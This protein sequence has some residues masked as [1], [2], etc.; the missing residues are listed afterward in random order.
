VS[1]NAPP[2][3]DRGLSRDSDLVAIL[4]N[5]TPCQSFKFSISGF[6]EIDLFAELG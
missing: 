2:P 6:E 3:S 5:L 1:G 4:S